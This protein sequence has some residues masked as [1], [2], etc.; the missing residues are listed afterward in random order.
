MPI[1]VVEWVERMSGE[2]LD[3]FVANGGSAVKFAVGNEALL[4]ALRSGLRD[5]ATQR[6]LLFF[7]VDAA[8]VKLHMIH[9]LFFALAREV[10]W[11][12][13]AQ[14]FVEGI[15]VRH[16]YSWPQAGQP[17]TIGEIAE[18]NLVAPNLLQKELQQWL[19]AEIW[20]DS[21]MTQDFRNA[22]MRLCLSRLE[23]AADDD[24]H[25][26][27]VLEW[28]RGELKAIAPLKSAGIF[29][30]VGR[31][32][33][34]SMLSSMCRWLAVTGHPGLLVTLDIRQLGKT[35]REVTS[36]HRYTNAAVMDAFEVLRQ[37]IDDVDRFEG[38]FLVTLADDALTDGLDVKRT[39]SGYT[40]L[41]MRI[42]ND[43]RAKGADNPLAPLVMLGPPS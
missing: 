26:L 40:A 17:V 28:L 2:Y 33:A 31:H 30:R 15:F 20:N 14:R 16:E 7:E 22:M 1:G 5:A 42:S 36:G 24:G 23:P 18:A 37:L 43:V 25:R 6:A 29:T 41:N 32:N 13:I 35:A 4:T 19:T 21:R 11:E 10:D 34:R 3:G 27:P 9:D 12:A 38:L 8:D 39:F